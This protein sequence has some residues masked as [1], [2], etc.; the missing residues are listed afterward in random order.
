MPA[1]VTHARLE[2][3]PENLMTDTAVCAIIA[4]RLL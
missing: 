1:T 2:H 3:M 4:V